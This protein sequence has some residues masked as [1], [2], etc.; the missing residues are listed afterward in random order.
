MAPDQGH[1]DTFAGEEFLLPG[2]D[3]P[4]E[5]RSL[6]ALLVVVVC[7]VLCLLVGL[8]RVLR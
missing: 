3:R 5:T 8:W 2:D 6:A 4:G 1:R 7:G